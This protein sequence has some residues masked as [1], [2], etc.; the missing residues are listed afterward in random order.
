MNNRIMVKEVLRFTEEL[1]ERYPERINNSIRN[2]VKYDDVR[3]LDHPKP[4]YKEPAI[5]SVVYED[6]ADTAFFMQQ[7]GLNPVAIN[8]ASNRTP[9][10]GWRNGAMA[11]EESLFYRSLYYLSLEDPW[12]LNENS[13]NYYPIPAYGAIYTPDVFF[14][15]SKQLDGFQ[16]LPYDQCAFISFLAVAAIRNPQLKSDGTYR[17]ADYRRMKE[18]VRGIF[19]IALK[20]GH[21]S[22][23]LGA[24]GCGAF[25]NP[26][27]QVADIICEIIKEYRYNFREIAIAILDYG[28]SK[29][30]PIFQKLIT[31]HY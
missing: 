3:E 4:E 15:R 26:P 20:H 7:R 11:Q 2:T 16:I 9:G 19:K 8:M 18:K 13:K 14:F 17:P 10:G 1:H 22:I 12:E 24:F 25:H 23:V 6:S 28:Q 27:E 30:F 5:V 31:S 21:D 29:N